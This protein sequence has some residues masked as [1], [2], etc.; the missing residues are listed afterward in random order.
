MKITEQSGKEEL[1]TYLEDSVFAVALLLDV[2]IARFLFCQCCKMGPYA[3]P[4]R[5][6]GHFS[7]AGY[8]N[9]LRS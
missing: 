2:G 6:E 1:N 3:I 9:E 5:G 7:R 8:V 4:F